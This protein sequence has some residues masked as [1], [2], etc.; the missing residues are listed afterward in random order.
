[1][2]SLP[3]GTPSV[4]MVW[5]GGGRLWS[6]F[7]EAAIPYILAANCH[8]DQWEWNIRQHDRA[9]T[10]AM[11]FAARALPSL[12]DVPARIAKHRRPRRQNGCERPVSWGCMLERRT[13]ETGIARKGRRKSKTAK[14]RR[15]QR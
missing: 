4:K 6:D 10:S 3:A 5:P 13:A 12:C 7:A 9:I 2:Q 11:S 8:A 1:M 14:P 15:R